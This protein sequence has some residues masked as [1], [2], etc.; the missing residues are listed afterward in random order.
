MSGPLGVGGK[1]E[2][3]SAPSGHVLP[4]GEE[5]RAEQKM[6]APARPP[7]EWATRL[8]TLVAVA[9][10]SVVAT[11]L[12]YYGWY[13]LDPQTFWQRLTTATIVLLP[14]LWAVV[15]TIRSL[16]GS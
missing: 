10:V 16:L 15:T 5:S 14:L 3:D 11:M 12:G 6:L 2:W 8:G 1:S 13:L 9:V 4:G 7:S